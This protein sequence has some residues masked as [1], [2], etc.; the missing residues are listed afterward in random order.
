[1]I[2]FAKQINVS[3]LDLKLPKQRF[4]EW[5]RDLVGREAIVH[6]ELNDCGE[7][8]G[9]PADKERDIPTCAQAETKLADNRKVV[10]MISVGTLKKGLTGKPAVVD[11]F[12][13]Q[14]G[15]FFTAIKLSELIREIKRKAELKARSN[16][17][18][19]EMNIKKLKPD[20]YGLMWA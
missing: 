6:W 9:S 13:E 2:A 7:Q 14:D 3:Q 10:V 19:I 5:F 17:T 12:I 20:P 1:M 11:A 15:H 4:D 8:T 18:I 16:L